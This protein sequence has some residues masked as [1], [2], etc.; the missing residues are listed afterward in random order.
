MN[1]ALYA[2]LAVLAIVVLWIGIRFIR[3]FRAVGRYVRRTKSSG[4]LKSEIR[5]HRRAISKQSSKE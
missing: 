5:R 3:E 4:H 1:Y 2:G